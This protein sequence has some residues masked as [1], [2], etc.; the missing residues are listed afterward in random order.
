[1]SLTVSKGNYPFINQLH[2]FSVRCNA[3]KFICLLFIASCNSINSTDI[4]NIPNTEDTSL[5]PDGNYREVEINY[6]EKL[7]PYNDSLENIKLINAS[8]KNRI[9]NDTNKKIISNSSRRFEVVAGAFSNNESAKKQLVLIKSKGYKN[10]HI[11]KVSNLYKVMVETY[12]NEK[13]ALIAVDKLKYRWG[14]DAIYR[15]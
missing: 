12:S 8:I 9:K 11:K 14:I 6:A 1:M 10:A 2:N 5:V 7:A 13:D 3:L 4:V 15:K